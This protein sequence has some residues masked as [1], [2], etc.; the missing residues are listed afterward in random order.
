MGSDP[1]ERGRNSAAPVDVRR[2]QDGSRRRAPGC[3]NW[4]ETS[5]FTAAD[6]G[7]M[8]PRTPLVVAALMSLTAGFS[9]L[10]AADAGSAAPPAT[11]A[12]RGFE[13]RF[14]GW[15]RGPDDTTGDLR[16]TFR[17]EGETRWSAE[18]T[19][20]FEGREYPTRTKSLRIDGPNLELVFEW[21]AEGHPAQS[22]VTGQ[23]EGDKL[24]GTYETSGGAGE[25][26]GRWHATRT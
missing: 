3:G 10:P 11:A 9:T 14:E 12:T 24:E 16:L 1:G 7:S 25:T 6:P 5:L 26:R 20:T 19:F 21:S 18:A 4:L 17:R 2:S 13:G 15:W 23:L 8:K 22:R